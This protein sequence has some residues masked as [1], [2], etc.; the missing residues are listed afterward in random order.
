MS[1]VQELLIYFLTDS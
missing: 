1:S